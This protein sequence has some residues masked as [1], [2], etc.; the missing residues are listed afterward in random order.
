MDRIAHETSELLSRAL[1]EA[2]VRI[3]G[4]LPRHLQNRLFNEAVISRG[5]RMRPLLGAILARAYKGK[6]FAVLPGYCHSTS[7]ALEIW[8]FIPDNPF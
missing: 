6:R 5:E 7:G 1:G 3:W 4:R 2:V 8:C